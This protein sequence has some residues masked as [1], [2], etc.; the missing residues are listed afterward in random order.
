MF[1]KTNQ[2]AIEGFSWIS[3]ENILVCVRWAFTSILYLL[4][5]GRIPR[6]T[7]MIGPRSISEGPSI[8]GRSAFPFGPI[9]I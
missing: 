9:Y 2:A 1:K 6:G 8:G 7:G 5:T 3:D 4:S